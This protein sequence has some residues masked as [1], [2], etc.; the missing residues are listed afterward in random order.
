[1]NT[2]TYSYPDVQLLI[3]GVWR[4]GAGKLTMPILDPATNETMS[5]LACATRED[6]DAALAAAGKGFEV[7]RKTSA[8]NR[9]RIMRKAA[10]IF[11]QRA[12]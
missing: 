9:A 4:R 2:A 5:S 12:E 7:W 11:R 6:L 10:E 1:L 3:D 8:Y